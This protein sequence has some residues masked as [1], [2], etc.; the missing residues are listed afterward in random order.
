MNRPVKAKKRGG[1]GFAKVCQL[2]PHLE[3]FLGSSQLA[4][5]EVTVYLFCRMV[6][7]CFVGL[8]N[9]LLSLCY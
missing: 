2:S 7:I 9:Y 3:K 5:T 8:I 6:Q 4:R 1:G